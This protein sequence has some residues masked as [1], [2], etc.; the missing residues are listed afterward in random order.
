MF[1]IMKKLLNKA[2]RFKIDDN[3][4]IVIMSDCHRGIGDNYDNFLKNRNLFLASLIHYYKNS[5]SYIEL[6]DGDEMWEVDNYKD[7]INEYIDVFKMLKKFNDSNRLIMI[8]GNHDIDKRNKLILYKYFYSYY[9]AITKKEEK[10]LNNLEVYE[11]II[12]EYKNQEMFLFHGH[13][14]DLLNGLFWRVSRFLVTHV[15][16]KFERI[17][18]S[19]P[20]GAIKNNKV[21]T[22]FEKRLKKWSIKNNKTVITGHTHRPI[23]PK[24]KNSLYFNDGSCI[25]PNGITCLEI[26]NGNITLVKWQY[27]LDHNN[28]ITVKRSVIEQSQSILNFYLKDC[29][30]FFHL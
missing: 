27:G 24:L 19:D 5:F 22:K 16:R 12:L 4:K 10:L 28:L 20:T 17:G 15:W 26:E 29:C 2:K 11:S 21:S 25:H 30:E 9:N 8:Y 18:V 23:F 1:R 14:V 6:G 13:Q 7:I 3:S